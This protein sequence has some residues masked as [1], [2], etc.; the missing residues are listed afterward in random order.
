MISRARSEIRPVGGSGTRSEKV[1]QM[2]SPGGAP[3]AAGAAAAAAPANRPLP[4]A[5]FYASLPQTLFFAVMFHAFFQLGPPAA[6][7][8]KGGGA[9]APLKGQAASGV[10]PGGGQGADMQQQAIPN[11]NAQVGISSRAR[12]P[13]I[14]NHAST[15]ASSTPDGK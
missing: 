8:N 4:W 3:A 12:F 11:A 6:Q 15:K 7:M 10:V 13:L 14:E 9:G 2:S 5:E 1:C